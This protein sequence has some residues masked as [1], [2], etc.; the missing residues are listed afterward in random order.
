MST[1]TY[2]FTRDKSMLLT[3]TVRKGFRN[4]QRWVKK[5]PNVDIH[6]NQV[7][8]SNVRKTCCYSLVSLVKAWK[9]ARQ[10]PHC[11]QV[12]LSVVSRTR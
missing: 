4:L 7:K 6:E 1:T 3:T 10:P 2:T 5:L 11:L 12:F 9:R 8:R